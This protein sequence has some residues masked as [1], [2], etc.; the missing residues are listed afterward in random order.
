MGDVMRTCSPDRRYLCLDMFQVSWQTGHF[1]TSDSAILLEIGGL[2]GLLQTSVEIPTGK[3]V[4]MAV[5]SGT[6]KAKV[7]SCQKDDFGY[8]VEISVDSAARWFPGSYA[9]TYVKAKTT[10]QPMK[11][12][13]KRPAAARRAR[14]AVAFANAWKPAKGGSSHR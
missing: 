5:P 11:S 3:T 1:K 14:K 9:P 12:P 10:E 13:R 4:T 8:L 7:T 6:L 2:G